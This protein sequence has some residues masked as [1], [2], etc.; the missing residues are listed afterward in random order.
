MPGEKVT[1][2]KNIKNK[3]NFK[4]VK[5][6][7]NESHLVYAPVYPKGKGSCEGE[8]SV[9]CTVTDT[10]GTIS[11]TKAKVSKLTMTYRG[12][13]PNPVLRVKKDTLQEGTDYTVMYVNTNAKGTATAIFT[14][15]GAYSGIMKKTFKVKAASI[16]SIPSENIVVSESAVYKK[17]GAK[18][19]ISVTMDGVK[20][21]TGVDY[22]VSYKNNKKVGRTATV[23]IKG[24]GNYSGKVKRD[25]QV[26]AE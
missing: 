20:L 22:T 3:V 2:G 5:A 16:T 11:I 14:G 8:F 12:S 10:N 13:M 23:T 18:P 19:D 4:I 15:Q 24:K 21:T 7:L 17:G 26:V 9:P 6:G 1:A 25:F